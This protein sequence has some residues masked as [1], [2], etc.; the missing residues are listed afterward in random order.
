MKRSTLVLVLIFL[1]GTA[2][3]Q[4]GIFNASKAPALSPHYQE[5]Y[6]FD[7]PTDP[8][9]W[10]NEKPGVHVSFGSPDKLYFRT[11][12]PDIQQKNSFGETGWRGERLNA[13]I[14][15]W[16]PDTIEQVH[17]SPGDLKSTTGELLKK[18]NLKLKKVN[19]VISN[20][21][22][23]A[24]DVDCGGSP[25]KDAY[26]MPDRFSAIEPFDVPGRTVRPVWLMIDIPVTQQPGTYSGNIEVN[27]KGFHTTLD[28]NVIVQSHT[29]PEGTDWKFRLDLWQNPWVVAWH[30][31]LE[32]WSDAHKTLL[33]EHLKLYADMGGKYIT[34]YAVH[35]PWS[36]NSY[37]IEG[38]MIDWLKG[39][40]GKWKFDYS[41]FDQYVELCMDAGVDEA[42]T[43]YTPVPW[44]NRF[45]YKDE[46]TGLFVYESWAPGTK[47]FKDH[48]NIFLTD[49]RS[50]LE[51]KGW[52]DKT[53]LGINENALEQ[54]LAA[55]KVIKDH[56][57]KWRITYAGDWH[58]ELD[59]L[60]DDY[61]FLKGKEPSMAQQRSRAARGASSTYYVCCTPAKPN[62]FVFSPP[63]EGRFIG[64]Y[65]IAFGYDGFLRWAYDAWP[66]D[67]MRDARHGS[68]AAG[69]C[70]LIY[71]GAN[72]CIRTEKLREGIADAEKIR[73]LRE[74][75]AKSTDKNV[76]KLVQDLEQ[77][78]GVM[79]AEK[80]L[81]ETKLAAEIEKG[82]NL[83]RQLS[84]VIK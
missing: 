42:I 48:W 14:V 5:E 71:P 22:Y 49:L 57:S 44:G 9:R 11:E 61:S 47:E 45:R 12:V 51:K 13:Q 53:Y 54:T 37:M 34:T 4:K 83:V 10:N 75:A 56:S 24:T 38:G 67:P 80:D 81:S 33:K 55:I 15:V 58:E 84:E 43:I 73:I 26:L 6:T 35:S 18:E 62:N 20:Y 72:S 46:S 8:A 25:Y 19:Y 23:G 76:K 27:A 21:P 3:S 74:K 82:R 66:G 36:D 50:H 68:W 69:D 78:L 70:F 60:L 64:W 28:L 39:T 31:D 32:P 16:S 65:S 7:Q 59:K 41:I 2:F 29:L 52:F 40:D 1:S 63:I 77:H 17:F 79:A 30:Y